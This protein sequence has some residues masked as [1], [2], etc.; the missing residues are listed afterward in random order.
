MRLGSGVCYNKR[1]IS[2][3]R[4]YRRWR[5][6]VSRCHN[7]DDEHYKHYGARGI[8]HHWRYDSAGYCAY[9][10]AMGERPP[11]GT[12]DRVDN[13]GDYAPGNLRWATPH[14]QEHNK[15]A[16]VVGEYRWVNPHLGKWHGGFMWR[17]VRY[18][19]SRTDTPVEAYLQVLALRS[20]VC[21]S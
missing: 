7:P 12:V 6:S 2:T 9:L 20:L 18:T 15:R 19:V 13:D 1:M 8:Q 4:Y 5:A 16:R 17:K 21:Q 11:G 3:H 14:E 10:D